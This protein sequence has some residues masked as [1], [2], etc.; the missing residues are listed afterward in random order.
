MRFLYEGLAVLLLAVVIAKLDVWLIQSA[1]RAKTE[2]QLHEFI[3]DWSHGT[4]AGDVE[5]FKETKQLLMLDWLD[6]R[7]G[8]TRIDFCHHVDRLIDAHCESFAINE[9]L[10]RRRGIRAA[11]Q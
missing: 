7:P 8:N 2:A 9:Y 6:A 5:R 10:K 1:K 3:R 4:T 11:R